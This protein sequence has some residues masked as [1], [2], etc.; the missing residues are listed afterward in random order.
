MQPKEKFAAK[1][2]ID[3]KSHTYVIFMAIKQS[4]L[5]FPLCNITA[6]VMTASKKASKQNTN[7]SKKPLS[8][9]QMF[10]KSSKQNIAIDVFFIKF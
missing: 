4:E 10:Q 8:R 7:V 9:I 2:D 6:N 5:S 3:K 1:I